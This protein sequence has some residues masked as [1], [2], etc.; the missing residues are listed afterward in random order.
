M[1]LILVLIMQILLLFSFAR[2][3]QEVRQLDPLTYK[4]LKNSEILK[5]FNVGLCGKSNLNS[6]KK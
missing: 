4:D 3:R 6:V 5:S 2:L 1:F